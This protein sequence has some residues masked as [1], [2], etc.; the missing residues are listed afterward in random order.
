[1]VFSHFKSHYFGVKHSISFSILN[2]QFI[3]AYTGLAWWHSRWE[4]ACQCR[5]HGFNPWSRKIPHAVDQLSPCPTT[6]EPT[7]YSLCATT[8]EVCML[9]GPRAATA[10]PVRCNYWG[11][12]PQGPCSTTRGPTVRSPQATRKSSPCSPQLE[13]AHARQWRLSAAKN[14]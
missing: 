6:A 14:K 7:L 2:K 1:M 8:V 4:S 3:K 13:K 12:R 11:P 5:Q 10:Q 9:E